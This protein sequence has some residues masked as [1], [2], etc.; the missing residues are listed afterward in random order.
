MFWRSVI[1]SLPTDAVAAE[2]TV[3]TVAV[4]QAGSG[5]LRRIRQEISELN[6]QGHDEAGEGS[7]QGHRGR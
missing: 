5:I 1:D 3:S 6:L 7:R 4:R 2:L